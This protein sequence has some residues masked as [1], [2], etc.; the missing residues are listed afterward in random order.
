MSNKI[1]LA[2]ERGGR[3]RCRYSSRPSSRVA[4]KP[5]DAFL[6][7]PDSVRCQECDRA[8]RAAAA[9][10]QPS[11]ECPNVK[12]NPRDGYYCD[13][14]GSGPCTRALQEAPRG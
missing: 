4:I 3:S 6:R 5:L 1:H 12:G 10:V 14:C 11:A 2:T 8:A 13:E 9:G 7:L